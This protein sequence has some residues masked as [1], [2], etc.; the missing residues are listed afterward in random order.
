MAGA[1]SEFPGRERPGGAA[2]GGPGQRV[3]D[4][5]PGTVLEIDEGVKCVSHE[6]QAASLA[7]L[8][9]GSGMLGTETAVDIDAAE[10]FRRS[11]Q[12]GDAHGH[13]SVMVGAAKAA[14]VAPGGVKLVIGSPGDRPEI[15]A[16]RGVGVSVPV[17]DQLAD[18]RAGR[19]RRHRRGHGDCGKVGEQVGGEEGLLHRSGASFHPILEGLR[20]YLRCSSAT[21]GSCLRRL[22]PTIKQFFQF[23]QGVIVRPRCSQRPFKNVVLNRPP[24]Q[25]SHGLKLFVPVRSHLNAFG[26]WVL[27][28]G[29]VGSGEAAIGFVVADNFAGLAVPTEA[30]AEFH[31]NVGQNAAGG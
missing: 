4:V 10:M 6:N 1:T 14:A 3:V 17:P 19:I 22:D 9:E 5:G 28:R 26:R 8:G 11:F 21:D 18:D 24:P 20:K 2:V 16:K 25:C 13:T 27:P 29:A 12:A 31:G 23:Q 7:F 15:T 30:A